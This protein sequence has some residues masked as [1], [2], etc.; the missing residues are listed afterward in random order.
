M[1]V[2]YGKPARAQRFEGLTTRDVIAKDDKGRSQE[3]VRSRRSG[4]VKGKGIRA[5]VERNV[6]SERLVRVAKG[7]KSVGWKVVGLRAD[8]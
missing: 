4:I 2:D 6:E 1:A 7:G 3:R 8:T 5:R